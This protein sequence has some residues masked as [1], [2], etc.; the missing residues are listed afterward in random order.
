MRIN[1][2]IGFFVLLIIG[3]VLNSQENASKTITDLGGL[4]ALVGGTGFAIYM[5]QQLRILK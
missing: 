3:V 2:L 4:L 1:A 5:L